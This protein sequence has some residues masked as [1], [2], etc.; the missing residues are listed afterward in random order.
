MSA[1][2]ATALAIGGLA[3]SSLADVQI[4][5]WE[6]ST[7]GWIDW[8]TGLPI[9]APKY[10]YSTA[11]VTSGNYALQ[12]NQTGWNQNLAIKLQNNGLVDDFMAHTKLQIDLTVPS[13][14]ESG[15]AKIEEITLN[16]QGANWGDYKVTAPILFGWPAG[17]GGAQSTTLVFDYSAYL[18]DPDVLTL[19]HDPWWVEIIITTN[20]DASHGVFLFDNAR[21]TDPVPEPAA[22]SVVGTVVMGL[23][24]RRRRA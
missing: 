23:L 24:C 17:G 1:A 9:A 7:D 16:A 6:Q 2:L 11:G 15:W 8:G 13:T 14:T 4:G 21:L 19:G 18:S 10:T 5:D 12:V 3:G 22:L 20:S